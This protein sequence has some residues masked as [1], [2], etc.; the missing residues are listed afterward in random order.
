MTNRPEHE[1]E[2]AAAGERQSRVLPGMELHDSSS[3][4]NTESPPLTLKP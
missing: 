3:S 2:H 4:M 1:Y